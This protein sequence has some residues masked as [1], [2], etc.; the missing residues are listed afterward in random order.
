MKPYSGNTNSNLGYPPYPNSGS[1]GS[2][3]SGSNNSY[4]PYPTN[5]G[6]HQQPP[7]NDGYPPYPTNN[8]MPLPG[9]PGYPYGGQPNYPQN[10]Q[11]PLHPPPGYQPGQNG[12]RYPGYSNYP[13]SN[14]YPQSNSRNYNNYYRRN[15][16]SSVT[17]S[18]ILMFTTTC[19]A[20]FAIFRNTFV[21]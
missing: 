15:S 20:L 11:Y 8:R 10:N 16:G 14:Y 4:P 3:S 13:N 5:Y 18:A 9:Q 12:Q 19:L 17:V 7:R 6:N 1:G 2:Q 21:P